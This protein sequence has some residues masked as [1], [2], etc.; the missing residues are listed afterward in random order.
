MESKNKIEYATIPSKALHEERHLHIAIPKYMFCT[1]CGEKNEEGSKFCKSCGASLDGKHEQKEEN[2]KSNEVLPASL[3]Q[4]LAHFFVDGFAQ[5]FFA[6]LVGVIGVLLFGEEFGGLLGII[7][8]FAY[9]FIFE[10]LFQKTVGK[11]FTGTKVVN[12]K[13]EKPRIGALLGRSLARY[14]PFE[15]LSFL[16]YGSHPTKGWHDRLSGTLVVPKHL[17]P[18]EVQQIDREERK[19]ESV[20]ALVLIIIAGGL[21]FLMVLGILSSVVLASL[22]SAREK[23]ADAALKTSLNEVRFYAELYYDEQGT[24]EGVCTD[25]DVQH[26][27]P[28]SATTLLG[29]RC[30]D[31][32]EGYAA[33]VPL[34]DDSFYCIDSDG[35]ADTTVRPLGNRITCP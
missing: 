20:G 26:V 4:R 32:A 21:F 24:Y 7:G 28:S 2:K 25:P 13:G 34:S 10:A 6:I 33:A 18:E 23:G 17:T 9:Y 19:H 8:F 16:F 12:L 11:I 22:N 3:L 30:N 31:T 14:I 29:Y 35:A 5:Y 1:Q 15:A 27:N